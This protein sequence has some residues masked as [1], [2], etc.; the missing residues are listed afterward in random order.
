VIYASVS[1]RDAIYVSVSFRDV[2][3][4]SVSFRDA[5]YASV[6]FRDAINRVSTVYY[7]NA[8]SPVK[9][10]FAGPFSIIEEKNS[11]LISNDTS[12][13]PPLVSTFQS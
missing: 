8:D 6:L 4:V 2:I 3:Y 10:S 1:F 12:S 11:S 9:T 13:F 5:I 7:N